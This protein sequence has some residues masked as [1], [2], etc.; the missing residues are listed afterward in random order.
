MEVTLFV[1]ADY[2]NKSADG[3]LNIL[4]IFNRIM[5]TSFPARHRQMF[6][7]IR[8]VAEL[9]EIRNKHDIR[10][11]FMDEDGKELI[12]GGGVLNIEHPKDG[13][14]AIAEFIVDVGDLHVPREGAYVFKLVLNQEIRARIPIEAILIKAETGQ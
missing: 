10:F 9:G 13:K 12:N 1:A 14:Q 3:K 2:A 7:V 8:L 5:A 4:G 6:L 11:L